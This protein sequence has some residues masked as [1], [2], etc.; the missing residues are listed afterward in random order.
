[1]EKKIWYINNGALF[2][3]EEELKYATWGKMDGTGDHNIKSNK[4][5]SKR[6]TSHFLSYVI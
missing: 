6:Q 4:P 2:S 3:H 5:D 1:M